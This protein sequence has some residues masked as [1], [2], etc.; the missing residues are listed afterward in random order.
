MDITEEM[1]EVIAKN[2]P[3]A[4]GVELEKVL[5][6]GRE[7]ALALKAALAS[8]SARAEAI[9]SL[10]FRAERAEALNKEHGDLASRAAKVAEAERDLK[11]RELTQDL[12]AARSMTA[13]ANQL[14]DKLVR[15]T[16]YRS[17]AFGNR[18]ELATMYPGGPPTQQVLP[19]TNTETRTAE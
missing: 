9:K 2:L 10:E 5:K 12:S 17:T 3:S 7:D 13:F 6:Q 16:E 14:M 4:V 15:N 19:T 8:L 11:V 1:Q 18:T